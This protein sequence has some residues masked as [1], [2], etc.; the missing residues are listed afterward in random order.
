MH[1]RDAIAADPAPACPVSS[2]RGALALPVL[3]RRDGSVSMST[4]R[5][6]RSGSMIG[7]SHDDA[8][9]C[10]PLQVA[11]PATCEDGSII[12]P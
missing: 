7:S 6:H 4:S 9:Y 5:S 10:A 3:V 2:Q 8:S 11:M 12:R 1:G